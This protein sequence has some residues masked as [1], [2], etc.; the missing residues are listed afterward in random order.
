[1]V[2]LAIPEDQAGVTAI[3][4][5]NSRLHRLFEVPA[6]KYHL[7]SMHPLQAGAL[8]MAT[9]AYPE[10]C[11]KDL[12]TLT[13]ARLAGRCITDAAPDADWFQAGAEQGVILPIDEKRLYGGAKQFD[14]RIR[15]RIDAGYLALQPI[16][17]AERGEPPL[18]SWGKLWNRSAAIRKA[19][20]DG[21]VDDPK[22]F[23]RRYWEPSAAVIHIAAAWVIML[24]QASKSGEPQGDA[25][26]VVIDSAYREELLQRALVLEQ[27]V[28]QSDLRIPPEILI[29]FRP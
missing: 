13:A 28:A 2:A 26:R 15:K 25:R 23:R 9:L 7:S 12:R 10:A 20:E 29:R 5:P 24:I 27:V 6:P 16:V 18:R 19:A 14:R 21:E 17:A 4:K 11:Y 8:L 1:M 3:A 22:N